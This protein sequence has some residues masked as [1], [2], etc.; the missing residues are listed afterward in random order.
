[1]PPILLELAHFDKRHRAMMGNMHEVTDEQFDQIIQRAMSE[2]PPDYIRN[3]DNVAIT[4]AEAPTDDQLTTNHVL[5]G[6]LLLGLYEGIPLTQ[7]GANYTH[8]LPDKITI[9]KQPILTVTRDEAE[10]FEQTKRT[11]WHEI[12]HHYG[13]EHNRIHTLEHK[14]R[15]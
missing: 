10:F 5:P 8:V 13:L 1:M 12:A 3:L 14:P 11:L 9:F 2:L 7:R 6:H 4:Y 15:D